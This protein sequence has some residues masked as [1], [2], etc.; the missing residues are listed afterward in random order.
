MIYE[1]NYQFLSQIQQQFQYISK[2]LTTLTCTNFYDF[3][4]YSII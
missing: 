2:Q 4:K 3:H 1:S